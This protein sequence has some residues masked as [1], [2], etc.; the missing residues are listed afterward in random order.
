MDGLPKTL[1]CFL[2][3]VNKQNTDF[4]WTSTEQNGRMKIFLMWT[5]DDLSTK[6][7]KQC[8]EKIISE[9]KT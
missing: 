5:N 2:N 8:V 4:S 6:R 7:L 1:T 3:I 9:N